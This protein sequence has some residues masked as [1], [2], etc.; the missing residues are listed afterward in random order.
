MWLGCGP[1]TLS[2]CLGIHNFDRRP[3]QTSHPSAGLGACSL[4]CAQGYTY[5]CLHMA[6]SDLAI[7]LVY[8]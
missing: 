7:R 3:L 6:I 5:G 4:D 8:K 2:V 1:L